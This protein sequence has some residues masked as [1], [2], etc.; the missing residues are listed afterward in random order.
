MRVE[1]QALSSVQSFGALSHN[2]VII[3]QGYKPGLADNS[4]DISIST[5]GING[6]G[7][8]AH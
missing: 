8:P 1:R 5:I 2:L 6:S 3:G 4:S 7:S